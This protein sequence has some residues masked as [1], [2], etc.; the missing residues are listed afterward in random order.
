MQ[1]IC[2]FN[3]VTAHLYGC[4]KMQVFH[5]KTVTVSVISFYMF[6]MFYMHVNILKTDRFMVSRVF[7]S[8]FDDKTFMICMCLSCSVQRCVV[9]NATQ[10][11]PTRTRCLACP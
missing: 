4:V 9:R 11:S 7:S 6:F 1:E 3:F 5:I 2:V 8:V 10:T